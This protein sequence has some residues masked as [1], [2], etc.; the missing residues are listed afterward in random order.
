MK[1]LITVSQVGDAIR[2]SRVTGHGEELIDPDLEIRLL[3]NLL[4]AR[5]AK[6]ESMTGTQL[7]PWDQIQRSIERLTD[8][9]TKIAVIA[10]K[11]DHSIQQAKIIAAAK[12]TPVRVGQ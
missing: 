3:A 2:V 8:A 4:W 5:L 6:G 7:A 12:P 10:E 1:T 11:L 9:V